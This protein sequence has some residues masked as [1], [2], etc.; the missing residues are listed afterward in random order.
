MG[1]NPVSSAAQAQI[2]GEEDAD[3]ID[4][5]QLFFSVLLTHEK[6]CA[7]EIERC[8][9]EGTRNQILWRTRFRKSVQGWLLHIGAGLLQTSRCLDRVFLLQS[10]ITYRG[11]ASENLGRWV[12]PLLQ[13]GPDTL[14]NSRRQLEQGSVQAPGVFEQI[15]SRVWSPLDVEN[16]VAMFQLVLQQ[17]ADPGSSSSNDGL[18]EKDYIAILEQCPWDAGVRNLF[19]PLDQ[20]QALEELGVAEVR[21]VF[22]RVHHVLSIIRETVQRLHRFVQLNK[23]LA[24]I[25][26]ALVSEAAS[27]VSALRALKTRVDDD[28]WGNA[29]VLFDCQCLVTTQFLLNSGDENLQLVLRELPLGHMSSEASWRLFVALV[30][31]YSG[32][33]L[34]HL[35]M[36]FGYVADSSGEYVVKVPNP[37]PLPLTGRLEWCPSNDEGVWATDSTEAVNKTFAALQHVCCL[38]DWIEVVN[39]DPAVR[40]HFLSFLKR[41]YIEEADARASAAK[42]VF[43]RAVISGTNAQSRALHRVMALSVLASVNGIDLANAVVR[44]LLGAIFLSDDAELQ[45]EG[46]ARPIRSLIG[47]I[48]RVH[49]QLVSV[50]LHQASLHLPKFANKAG[51]ALFRSIPLDQWVPTIDADVRVLRSWLLPTLQESSVGSAAPTTPRSGAAGG[52][53]MRARSSSSAKKSK[54]NEDSGKPLQ[55]TGNFVSP[56]S[57]LAMEIIGRLSLGRTSVAIC[58]VQVQ[59]AVALAVIESFVARWSRTLH[60]KTQNTGT[61]ATLRRWNPLTHEYSEDRELNQFEAWCWTVLLR[62]EFFQ[63]DSFQRAGDVWDVSDPRDTSSGGLLRQ[64]WKQ[65]LE[66]ARDMKETTES[67]SSS[68][69]AAAAAAAAAGG[70]AAGTGASAGGVTGTSELCLA[71]TDELH[72]FIH[73]LLAYI[74]LVS[75]NHAQVRDWVPLLVLVHFADPGRGSHWQQVERACNNVFL[76]L[77]PGA[78]RAADGAEA[79]DGVPPLPPQE[80]WILNFFRSGPTRERAGQSHLQQ[81]GSRAS[82][83]LGDV[84]TRLGSAVRGS[85]ESTDGNTTTGAGVGLSPRKITRRQSR[86]SSTEE[87]PR[88]GSDT[89]APPHWS[90]D[91]RMV[92]CTQIRVATMHSSHR[93]LGKLC[94]RFWTS[95]VTRLQDW[96][97]DE[98]ARLVLDGIAQTCF[99]L[100]EHKP[101]L[102]LLV[103][104]DRVLHRVLCGEPKRLSI[105]PAVAT[106]GGVLSKSDA[107]EVVQ[108]C[109]WLSFRALLVETGREFPLWKAIG[110]VLSE[111]LKRRPG[112]A[113]DAIRPDLTRQLV[114]HGIAANTA[115]EYLH[116]DLRKLSQYRIY[117]WANHALAVDAEHPFLVPYWQVL[118]TMLFQ[119]VGSLVVGFKFLHRSKRQSRRSNLREQLLARAKGLN[120]YF[121]EKHRVLQHNTSREG[122]DAAVQA[123]TLR[124]ELFGAIELWLREPDPTSWLGDPER[125]DLGQLGGA[126]GH[127]RL[128][129]VLSTPLLSNVHSY[130]SSLDGND[131]LGDL[132]AV[133]RLLWF[134]LVDV[135]EGAVTLDRIASWSLDRESGTVESWRVARRH[136]RRRQSSVDMANTTAKVLDYR[137]GPVYLFRRHKVDHSEHLLAKIDP[138]EALGVLQEGTQRHM[139]SLNQQREATKEIIS[140]IPRLYRQQTRVERVEKEEKAAMAL[141]ELTERVCW[142]VAQLDAA[143]DR[144]LS[145]D[146]RGAH[147]AASD[148]EQDRLGVLWF[149]ALLKAE[150][151]ESRK[152]PPAQRTIWKGLAKLG[153]EFGR[154]DSRLASEML[155][156]MIE[157]ANR[158]PLLSPLFCPSEHIV[159]TFELYAELWRA[160]P[161]LKSIDVMPVLQRFDFGA[162]MALPPPR[163]LRDQFLLMLGGVLRQTSWKGF[164]SASKG[165][166]N[167]EAQTFAFHCE[168]FEQLLSSRFADHAVDALCVVIGARPPRLGTQEST[169]AENSPEGT[170]GVAAERVSVALHGTVWKTLISIDD[171][172][173]HAIPFQELKEMCLILGDH[174]FKLRVGGSGSAFSMCTE[175]DS[176]VQQWS[177]LGLVDWF[178][179]LARKL[180]TLMLRVVREEAAAGRDE[181]SSAPLGRPLHLLQETWLAVCAMYDPWL[182]SRFE[183][184]HAGSGDSSAG[185]LLQFPTEPSRA[186]FSHAHRDEE[187]DASAKWR[188]GAPW[189]ARLAKEGRQVVIGFVECVHAL[190]Q[191]GQ[192][193]APHWIL[194]EVWTHYFVVLSM[195]A[196]PD[197]AKVIVDELAELEWRTWRLDQDS[198]SGVIHIVDMARQGDANMMLACNVLRKLDWVQTNA[199]LPSDASRARFYALL[200]GLMIDML[201]K[202][203]QCAVNAPLKA[204]LTQVALGLPW[205]NVSVHD[206]GQVI[207]QVEN[208]AIVVAE[209]EPRKRPP[210]ASVSLLMAC[211]FLGACTGLGD[212]RSHDAGWVC[213][214][215]GRESAFV[216]MLC[217]TLK[218]SVRNAR[219]HSLKESAWGPFSSGSMVLL[220]AL[221]AHRFLRTLEAEQDWLLPC[222]DL[223]SEARSHEGSNEV[224]EA[225]Q[226]LLGSLISFQSLPGASIVSSALLKRVEERDQ[227]G[228]SEAVFGQIETLFESIATK[229]RGAAQIEGHVDDGHLGALPTSGDSEEGAAVAQEKGLQEVIPV[230]LAASRQSIPFNVYAAE[231]PSA[232]LPEHPSGTRRLLR[233]RSSSSGSAAL[234]PS[235]ATNSNS[236]STGHA[237]REMPSITVAGIGCATARVVVD[238]PRLVPMVTSLLEARV[239]NLARQAEVLEMCLEAWFTHSNELWYAVSCLEGLHQASQVAALRNASLARGAWLTVHALCVLSLR[240]ELVS[241][242]RALVQAVDSIEAC[243]SRASQTFLCPPAHKVIPMLAIVCELATYL[244]ERQRLEGKEIVEQLH[245]MVDALSSFTTTGLGVIANFASAVI[246]K[247]SSSGVGSSGALASAT[248]T[249]AATASSTDQ[250]GAVNNASSNSV[251]RALSEDDKFKLVARSLSLLLYLNTKR[252]T[253]LVRI[254]RDQVQNAQSRKAQHALHQVSQQDDAGR[255]LS[256]WV[257]RYCTDPIHTLLGSRQLL[258][259]LTFNLY[260]DHVFLRRPQLEWKASVQT[261]F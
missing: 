73:P 27:F 4:Q 115:A 23:V 10:V 114:A 100:Q 65:G 239:E 21:Q 133:R 200:M 207:L 135:G 153:R 148:V 140:C 128:A 230:M 152:Y 250:E 26:C 48:M 43:G 66:I 185:S 180:T 137:P 18:E 182:C 54:G 143:I 126:F 172:H 41:G 162:W 68:N 136:A 113:L 67:S 218:C 95:A 142:T 62:V 176:L 129:A 209:Q 252:S 86:S 206:F 181:S 103:E 55:D 130:V 191:L 213:S 159:Q 29:Q 125:A 20:H 117:R 227:G 124:M 167:P 165:T 78:L 72:P 202:H 212:L 236:A 195:E 221:A 74:M 234:P 187:S 83:I 132:V 258:E 243:L 163:E 77:I 192:G 251:A 12:L 79:R 253:G 76:H 19:P 225:V 242:E 215:L 240:K 3:V 247:F 233:R 52:V 24:T 116:S 84:F 82:G 15:E 63:R 168:L 102:E 157:D 259:E 6:S 108:G 194:G 226:H 223:D 107:S 22:A 144:L 64:L 211:K 42:G 33:D 39:A 46:L 91:L 178:G 256:N 260:P 216:N 164:A 174:L 127:G 197:V 88:S 261:R 30:V 97:A 257:V 61:L 40:K 51:E 186:A 90:D 16:F 92:A 80:R 69:S 71:D 201:R 110:T 210:Q 53:V 228:L 237:Q 50:V 245:R 85:T 49:P 154:H 156:S 36:I 224:K 28:A 45:A 150:T 199:Q 75:T 229:L 58:P 60:N 2:N 169:L 14:G 119:H 93:N 38:A 122:G 173:W 94:V 96:A 166:P 158:V 138:E 56:Q 161:R 175:A 87:A 244:A 105:L 134:D 219:S 13:I 235:Q 141:D 123:A 254:R 81:L 8:S 205:W 70:V 99:V 131:A 120:H 238:F 57:M 151:R 222:L 249:G 196:S 118:V 188:D 1:S 170:H 241:P 204:F 101:C 155:S 208:W 9:A 189:P 47:D 171:T 7:R 220:F 32:P 121:S 160:I 190:T 179:I 139:R 149:K 232:S 184:P 193:I 111:T 89:N 106:L 214:G 59:H 25:A 104:M 145:P 98:G 109:D 11:L 31:G 183:S 231:T 198:L 147:Q 248:A 112:E 255:D 35:D 37:Q 5:V 34:A 203:D 177:S 17:A 217:N 44:E 146:S 246:G